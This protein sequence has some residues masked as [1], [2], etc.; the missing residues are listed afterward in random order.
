MSIWGE[1]PWSGVEEG[2][3]PVDTTPPSIAIISPA[4]GARILRATQLI[5]EVTDE[6][7]LRLVVPAVKINDDYELI[8]DGTTFTPKYI[9]SSTREA[10]VNGYRYTVN[11][12][13]GWPEPEIGG[14]LLE[15]Q[16]VP[17]VVD[18]GGNVPA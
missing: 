7:G 5:F 17:F 18:T 6:S 3:G 1:S 13:G 16:L 8:H 15:I 9:D 4:V 12:L 2:G 11:R 14:D 10:I